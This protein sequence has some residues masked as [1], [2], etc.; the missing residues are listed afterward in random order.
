[1][2]TSHYRNLKNIVNKN[3]N[4]LSFPSPNFLQMSRRK[5]INHVHIFIL[6]LAKLE[7]F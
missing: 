1:M 2:R 3:V 7:K 6:V 4:H 5:K